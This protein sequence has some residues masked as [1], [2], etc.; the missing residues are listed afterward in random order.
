MTRPHLHARPPIRF[1]A[2]LALAWLA[3]GC[4]AERVLEEGNSGW[5]LALPVAG[6]WGL[7]AVLAWLAPRRRGGHRL[8]RALPWSL[9]AAAVA[10]FVFAAVNLGAELEPTHKL[11]NIGLWFL[12]TMLGAGAALLVG[13]RLLRPVA[14]RARGEVG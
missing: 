4:R 14:D 10:A 5:W 11:W 8:H 2:L 3:S 1:A 6:L 12:G 7:T 9:A 13:E